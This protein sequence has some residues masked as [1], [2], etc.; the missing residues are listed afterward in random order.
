MQFNKEIF[1]IADGVIR[2]YSEFSNHSRGC[3][4][5]HELAPCCPWRDDMKGGAI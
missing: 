4:C 1:E 3:N 2:E 5:L